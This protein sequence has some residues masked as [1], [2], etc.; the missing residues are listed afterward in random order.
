MQVNNNI[1]NIETSESAITAYNINKNF[2]RSIALNNVNLQIKW[3]EIFILIG[4]N[5]SGKSTLVKTLSMLSTPDSGSIKLAGTNI[6][7]NPI[8]LRHITGTLTHNS[9]LY[10]QLS[11]F[12]NLVFTA[13]LFNLKNYEKDIE[14]SAKKLG[15]YE[16]I[17]DPV[18]T[19]S[20]GTKKKI[21]LIKSILHQ[22]KI[23]ILDEPDSGLDIKAQNDL[24]SI[25]LKQKKLNNTVLFTTHNIE[26]AIE[27][28]DR[29]GIINKGKIINISHS[30]N[31]N[32]NL[33]ESIYSSK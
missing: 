27:I 31:F 16:K 4:P 23:L 32:K 13:K 7:N 9:L 15:I 10:D 28:G 18:Y 6:K 30:K 25:I 24:N 8:Y 22:P 1:P 21:S 12:E 20:H 19:M 3:G 26:K 29:I 2:G 33:I 17:F 14:N 11:G 5:G